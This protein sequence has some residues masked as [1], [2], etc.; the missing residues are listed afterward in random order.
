MVS[1][2]TLQVLPQSFSAGMW[3]AAFDLPAGD[4]SATCHSQQ[5][6]SITGGT[7]Y[8]NLATASPDTNGVLMAALGMLA[9][10]VVATRCS[11]IPSGLLPA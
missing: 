6:A 7:C 11:S 10:P 2:L 9:V 1:A 4:Q 3:A 5:H 8:P